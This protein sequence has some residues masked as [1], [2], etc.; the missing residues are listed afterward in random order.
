MRI[1]AF[2]APW[3][4]AL[5]ALVAATLCV[6]LFMFTQAGDAEPGLSAADNAAPV[7]VGA[8][9]TTVTTATEALV[10]PP[11]ATDVPAGLSAQQWQSLREQYAGKPG[12]EAE[13]ARVVA[14]LQYQQ[15]VQALRQAQKQPTD[16]AA[17]RAAAQ[18][19]DSGL[20]ERISR[21]E[22]SAGEALALK[23]AALAVLQ[24]DADARRA[25]LAGWRAAQQADAG[26]DTDRQQAARFREG[27][28]ALLA[29][30]RAQPA[31]QRDANQ[32]AAQ[33]Q[34]LREQTFDAPPTTGPRPSGDTR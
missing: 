5:L 32:L 26:S 2:S 19:V 25:E 9:L 22:V 6:V 31:A 23:A 28:A 33:L 3:R 8:G 10:L 34:T 27:E 24:P 7:P 4:V 18:Q 12:G 11:S 1:S 30:Y 29:R 16:T 15:A 13:I 21:G 20:T 14:Y 17:L